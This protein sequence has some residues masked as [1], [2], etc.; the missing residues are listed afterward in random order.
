MP[1]T[2]TGFLYPWSVGFLSLSIPSQWK[3]NLHRLYNFNFISSLYTSISL[4]YILF[5][6]PW[7]H[8]IDDFFSI[9]LQWRRFCLKCYLQSILVDNIKNIIWIFDNLVICPYFDIFLF[10][11]LKFSFYYHFSVQY[12]LNISLSILNLYNTLFFF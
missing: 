10:I 12:Q 11:I 1:P 7:R 3:P 6:R 8:F 2:S 4:V 5:P 9:S